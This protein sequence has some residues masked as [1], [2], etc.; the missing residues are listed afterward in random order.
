MAACLRE[1]PPFRYPIGI[2]YGD[3]KFSDF[4]S[5]HYCNHGSPEWGS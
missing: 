1:L 2:R 5:K 3:S 4:S